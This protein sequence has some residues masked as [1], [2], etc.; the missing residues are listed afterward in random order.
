MRPPIVAG[1]ISRNLRLVIADWNVLAGAAVGVATGV[2][3]GVGVA[4]PFGLS[5]WAETV[6]TAVNSSK[7]KKKNPFRARSILI[8]FGPLETEFGLARKNKS[9][10]HFS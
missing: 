10:L 1:P 7:K 6:A 8:V 4:L 9:R 5:F 2:G 3:A